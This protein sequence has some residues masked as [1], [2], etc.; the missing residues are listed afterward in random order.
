MFPTSNLILPFCRS[1]PLLLLFPKISMQNLLLPFLLCSSFLCT[2]KTVLLLLAISSAVCTA[3]DLSALPHK[4]G[5]L[6]FL[7]AGMSQLFS[8]RVV[9]KAHCS[10]RWSE[11]D[12]GGHVAC[13]SSCFLYSLLSF[14]FIFCFWLSIISGLFFL[15][16][17]D[18]P[19]SSTLHL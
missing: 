11:D 18:Q 6:I 14:R 16:K 4:S 8:W 2:L 7:T 17:R 5:T 19:M 13:S 3:P 12:V 15:Q 10:Y 1:S 9:S